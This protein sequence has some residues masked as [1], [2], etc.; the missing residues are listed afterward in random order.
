MNS[1]DNKVVEMTFDNSQFEAA[2]AKTMETLD[3][4]KNKL[5]FGGTEKG[6]DK[7]GKAVTKTTYSLDDIGA[8]IADIQ[9][10]FNAMGSLGSMAMDRLKNKAL[11]FAQNGLSKLTSS[12]VQGG[13]SRAMNLEQAQFQLKGILKDTKKVHTFIYDWILP[14]LQGTPF[15]LDQAAVVMGQLAASGKKSEE[16]IRRATRGIAGL[17][18]MTN[19]SFA[20][21]GRIFTKVA[22]NGVMMAEE[23]NQ[24]SGYGINAAADL[25]QYYKIVQKDNSKGTKQTLK[26]MAAIEEAFGKFNEQTIR[27]AASKRMIHYGSMAAAMDTL[28]GEHA[29]ESTTMYTGALEDL[30]AALARVGAE[31]QAVKL[32]ALRDAF[33]ALVPAVDVVNGVLKKFTSSAKESYIEIGKNG[34]EVT[35]YKK[36]FTGSLAKEVQ[37][38]AW[39]FQKLFV[40]LDANNDI[41]R[42][43]D[44]TIKEFANDIKEVTKEGDILL[45]TGQV[46]SKGDAIMNPNMW[47]ILTDSTWIFVN[48]LKAARKVIETIFNS[49]RDLLPSITLEKIAKLT[50]YVRKFTEA[51]IPGA[52]TLDRIYWIARGVFAPLNLAIHGAIGLI[53]TLFNILQ[54]LYKFLKPTINA[55]MSA[56]SALGKAIDGIG[57]SLLEAA[58]SAA[59]FGSKVADKIVAL[60]KFFKIDV[61]LGKIQEKLN[62]FSSWMD[63]KGTKIG[64]A[65]GNV[66]ARIKEAGKTLGNFLNISGKI[67]MVVGLVTKI[68]DGIASLLGLNMAGGFLG[69]LWE[70]FKS[71]FGDDAIETGTEKLK[72]FIEW[73]G[74]LVPFEDV[75]NGLSTGFDNLSGKLQN[76]KEKVSSN[77]LVGS[78]SYLAGQFKTLLKELFEGEF[79][80]TFFRET[81][82]IFGQL[83][84]WK[85]MM[86]RTVVGTVDTLKKFLSQL[87]QVSNMSELATK[88]GR[89]ISKFFVA[90]LDFFTNVAKVGAGDAAK[91]VQHMKDAAASVGELTGKA[92]SATKTKVF[93]TIGTSFKTIGDIFRKFG[94]SIDPNVARKFILSLAIFAAAIT[95]I[96]AI[97]KMAGAITAVTK[98]LNGFGSI[99]SSIAA[100]PKQISGVFKAIKVGTYLMTFALSLVAIAGAMYILSMIDSSKLLSAAGVMVALMI[101]LGLVFV[102]LFK[103]ADKIGPTTSK[104]LARTAIVIG[105]IAG[106]LL[107]M[108]LSFQILANIEKNGG[109]LGTAAVVLWTTI[110]LFGLLLKFLAGFKGTGKLAVDTWA[111]VGLANGCKTMA[112]AIAALGDIPKEKVGQGAALMAEIMLFFSLFAFALSAFRKI[113]ITGDKNKISNGFFTAGLMI[114]SLAVAIKMIVGAISDLAALYG[115]G[116]NVDRARDVIEEMLVCFSIFSLFVGIAGKLGGNFLHATAALFAASIA[117][118]MIASAIAEIAGITDQAAVERA[119]ATIEGILL[120]AGL[121]G[122]LGAIGGTGAAI[123]MA[124]L[125]A[126][127]VGILAIA[128]AI[129][130]LCDLDAS[131]AIN[132]ISGIVVSVL[133]LAAAFWFVSQVLKQ[134]IDV[135]IIVGVTALAA[136]TLM[137]AISIG[138]LASMPFES[139]LVA[140]VAVVAVLASTALVLAA[141]ATVAGPGLAIIA[142][143]FLMLGTACLFVG[144]GLFLVTLA[145]ST[146]IPLITGLAGVDTEKLKDGLENL[147]ITAAGLGDAFSAVASGVKD[148]G[149]ALLWVGGGLVIIAVGIAL[150][151]VGCLVAA[152]GV[153][154]LSGALI[155]LYETIVTFFPALLEPITGLFSTLVGA[156]DKFFG[157]WSNHLDDTMDGKKAQQWQKNNAEPMKKWAEELGNNGPTEIKGAVDK[158]LNAQNEEIIAK[159]PETKEAQK[160]VTTAQA[161]GIKEGTPAVTGAQ[162][163]LFDY[164][165]QNNID[166]AD[167]Q[168]QYGL[169]GSINFG[170]GFLEGADGIAPLLGSSGTGLG[171][172]FTDNL[173]SA[174]GSVP[175]A[176]TVGEFISGEDSK[177]KEVKAEASKIADAGVPPSRYSSS[178]KVGS[179][180]SQGLID[181]IKGKM[182]TIVSIAQQAA[183]AAAKAMASRK[184]ADVNSPSKKTIPIGSALGEGLIVGMS[185][186]QGQVLATGEHLGDKSA[187]VIGKSMQKV[188]ALFDIDTDFTPTITP[189]VNLENV[190]QSADSINGILGGSF[191][192]NTPYSGL[193][194]AQSVA[195]SFQNRPNSAEFTAINKLAKEIGSMNET[196]NARSIN[197]YNTIDGSSDP[198]AFADG[199]IRSFRLNARTV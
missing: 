189:V 163:K 168:K 187:N 188:A 135:E 179:S 160:V 62:A 110:G 40:Q 14:E 171:Q 130:A 65:L 176:A 39:A 157:A 195:A 72:T 159:A 85:G 149:K 64:I 154:V 83:H 8:S 164:L 125:A 81:V 44:K 20:D 54:S 76:V 111:L 9:N 47:K 184:G 6:L 7:V 162:T 139:L 3:K 87:F 38:A 11:D 5:N 97:R 17:A 66:T 107:A 80:V 109:D 74:G 118:K 170:N 104:V 79:F 174:D 35:K 67:Q 100:L 58:G 32:E 167:L 99:F 122:L 36:T 93:E 192:L 116:A 183:D 114:M 95:Y 128:M 180:L 108:A 98:V 144:G 46:A 148:F 175:G 33:N 63:R 177:K 147:K 59:S 142:L 70:G 34:K 91:G 155:V 150:I 115:A 92:A 57:K 55:I 25:V 169:N 178:Y 89:S 173:G 37:S 41:L 134:A 140:C 185:N 181:G 4:F 182:D 152:A 2:V 86:M 123:G 21:V 68:R 129:K 48:T 96:R 191:G 141:L 133:A 126:V 82:P 71:L 51:L 27:E 193:F 190:R 90:V 120:I 26:D 31:A 137:F 19:H 16:Q 145:L 172:I 102:A 30:K 161:E 60:L 153:F 28:Y 113:E 158:V 45:K 196:M 198:E 13:L 199:M 143:G 18:A 166:F 77:G 138:Y 112:E 103:L 12:V 127:A 52:Q 132:G 197:V 15:S 117:I 50:G 29:K 23:L 42:W 88:A 101:G 151:G 121:I 1:I 105:S 49:A 136:A 10:G 24:L 84:K 194:N 186:I 61:L 165:N 43:N 146:L 73:L 156:I 75:V 78:I 53:K 124:S 56:A 94:N 69:G 131:Q 106:S 119:S 22:G